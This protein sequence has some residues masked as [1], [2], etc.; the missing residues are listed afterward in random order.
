M[1]VNQIIT[2][3]GQRISSNNL[4]N[5]PKPAHLHDHAY[6]SKQQHDIPIFSINEPLFIASLW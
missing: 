3:N 4:Q 1:I 5:Q 2:V 6:Y